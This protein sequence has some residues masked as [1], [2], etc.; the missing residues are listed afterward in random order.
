MRSNKEGFSITT[1]VQLAKPEHT[2][3]EFDLLFTTF[4]GKL[5]YIVHRFDSITDHDVLHL[6]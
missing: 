1:G 3:E 4:L 2:N 6:L 5:T